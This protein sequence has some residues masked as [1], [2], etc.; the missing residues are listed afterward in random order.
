MERFKSLSKDSVSENEGK[1]L[2]K[3]LKDDIL[4]KTIENR[5]DAPYFVFYDGSKILKRYYL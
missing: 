4:N 2:E 5:L 1:I 3:W